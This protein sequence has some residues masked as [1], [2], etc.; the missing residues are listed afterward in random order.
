[1]CGLVQARQVHVHS[2]SGNS[3]ASSPGSTAQIFFVHIVWKK[4]TWAVEPGICA[5][6]KKTLAVEPG[7]IMCKKKLGSRAWDMCKKKPWQ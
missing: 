3:V 4:K 2:D 6:E 5:G 1:M 7:I